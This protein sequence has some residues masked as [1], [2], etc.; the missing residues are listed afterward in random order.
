MQSKPDFATASRNELEAYLR[1]LQAAEANAAAAGRQ[2]AVLLDAERSLIEEAAR[3]SGLDDANR[4]DLLA[5]VGERHSRSLDRVN[6]ML[7]A[8]QDLYRAMQAA[9]A[10]VIVEFGKYKVGAD[11]HVRFANKTVESRSIAVNREINAAG[12]ALD[13]INAEITRS[14]QISRWAPEPAW[15]DMM[16]WSGKP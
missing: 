11:G 2:Y 9:Q 4:G 8:R 3:S 6:R 1:D 13:R 15:K 5:A 12:D 16:M 10:M 14:Q 7:Q